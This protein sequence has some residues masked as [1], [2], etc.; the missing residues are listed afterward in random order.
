MPAA[1]NKSLMQRWLPV[2]VGPELLWLLFFLA[3]KGLIRFTRSPQ[4]RMDPF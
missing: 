2:L 4:K 3:I 1:E